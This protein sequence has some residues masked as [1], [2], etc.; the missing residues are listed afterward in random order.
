MGPVP[1]SLDDYRRRQCAEPAASPASP[2]TAPPASG[3]TSHHQSQRA[4]QGARWEALVESRLAFLASHRRL[5]WIRTPQPHRVVGHAHEGVVVVFTGD[6]PPDYIIA[7][8]GVTIAADAKSTTAERWSLSL[9]ED[10]QAR[11][12]DEL[13]SHGVVGAIFLLLCGEAFVLPWQAL[14]GRWWTWYATL[15]RADNGTASLSCA[16]VAEMGWTMDA[17]GQWLDRLKEGV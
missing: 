10:H 13:S 9:L 7:T 6:G 11:S 16:D 17:G 12:L 1:V 5:A 15:G 14:R 4:R 2:S 3:A 8:G